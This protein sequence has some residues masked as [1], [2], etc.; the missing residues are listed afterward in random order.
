M[1]VDSLF[2]NSKSYDADF[3]FAYTL[4]TYYLTIRRKLE[5]GQMQGAWGGEG[6]LKSSFFSVSKT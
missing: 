4:L 6:G 5:R 1:Y 2:T 3:H